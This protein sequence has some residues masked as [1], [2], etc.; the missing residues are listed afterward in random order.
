MGGITSEPMDLLATDIW[1]WCLLRQIHISA[2]YVPGCQNTADFYSRN[3]S[4]STEW[5]LKMDIFK[6]L[7]DHFFVPDID[8]FSSR[9][10]KQLDVFVSWF[11]EPGAL[12]CDAFSFSWHNYRPYIFPPFSLVGKVINKII[13]DKV[14]KAILVFP[15]WKSQSWF[16]LLLD[17]SFPVRLPRHKDLLVLPPDLLPITYKCIRLQLQLLCNFMITDYNYNY[18]FPECNQLQL[19]LHCN[20]ID[21]NYNYFLVVPSLKKF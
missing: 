6:C 11:P 17:N 10:N 20:V 5:Q 3:F 13:E 7:C 14:E 12:H 8:L 4:D 19:Q 21:Y 2:V 16:P 1:E 18:I 9:L 15:L